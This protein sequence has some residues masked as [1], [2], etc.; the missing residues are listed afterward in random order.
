MAFRIRHNA[1]KTESKQ[2]IEVKKLIS[3]S[4]KI[5]V[6]KLISLS[7][8]LDKKQVKHPPKEELQKEKDEKKSSFSVGDETIIYDE[9]SGLWRLQHL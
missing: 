4:K 2:K 7:K 6:K 3:L 1:K 9:K 8:K 5:E